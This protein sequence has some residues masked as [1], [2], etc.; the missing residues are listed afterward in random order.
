MFPSN[1]NYEASVESYWS[2]TARLAPACFVLPTTAQ[3]VSLAVKTLVKSNSAG[4]CRFAIRGGGHTPWPGAANIKDGVT[5]DLSSMNKVI[6]DK[7]KS[8]ASIGP[9]ARWTE[10]FEVLEPLGVAVPGGRNG[11]VGVGGFTLGGNAAVTCREVSSHS[12]D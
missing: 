12:P 3:D 1:P 6:Y 11:A 5:I 4:P 10:V 9:G 7:E 8:M 2:V